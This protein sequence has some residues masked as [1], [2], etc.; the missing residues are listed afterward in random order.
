[1]TEDKVRIIEAV[2]TPIAFF[3][4][5]ILLVEG[6]L[7]L[8]GIKCPEQ[9]TIVIIGM[10]ALIFLLIVIVTL[11]SWCRPEA[12]KGVRFID[13][14]ELEKIRQNFQEVEKMAEMI[15]GK[16]DIVST[17]HKDGSLEPTEAQAACEITKGRY[18]IIMQGSSLG[19]DG[20]IGVNFVVKQAFVSEDGLTFIFQVPQN[21]GQSILGVGQVRFVSSANDRKL[22][23]KMEGN[24]GVLGSKTSGK[25]EFRRKD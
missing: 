2:K 16:W 11:L 9:R 24:W 14:P 13:D 18:G 25:I 19:P 22:I 7:G 12:L 4:L 10:L 6:V 5:V 17:Y 15:S 1:M 23:D 20:S 21:L 3:V 8:V